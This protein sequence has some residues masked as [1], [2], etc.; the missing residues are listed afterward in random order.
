[1]SRLYWIHSKL[2]T[3]NKEKMKII[4][5]II[6]SFFILCPSL[7]QAQENTNQGEIEG[8]QVVI[9]KNLEITLPEAERNFE[10]VPPP[11][12]QASGEENLNYGF[13]YVD[14]T[15]IP[16][17]N[18][19]LRI[20][21][22]KTERPPLPY[23]NYAK[24]GFGNYLSPYLDVY[25]H[26]TP[27]KNASYGANVFHHSAVNGPVDGKNS[28]NGISQIRLHG[29]YMG[30]AVTTGAN[31]GYTTE[32]YR[33]YGY[34][35]QTEVDRDTIKQVFRTFNAG[36]SLATADP[37]ANLRLKGGLNF[38]HKG[39]NFDISE[40]AVHAFMGGY[41]PI[42][43]GISAG[44]DLD[45]DFRSYKGQGTIS[46]NLIRIFPYFIYQSGQLAVK[47]GFN[48]IS[49]N[50]TLNNVS[51]IG[52]YPSITADYFLSEGITVFGILEGNVDKFNFSN[53]T[54][55]NPY[56]K[57]NVPF[58]NTIKTLEMG[59]GIKG[60]VISNLGYKAS[61]TFAGYKNM[62]FFVND[63]IETNKFNIVYD[64]DM[65]NILRLSAAI[66]YS[67]EQKYGLEL[68][69]N[70]F[71]YSTGDVAEAWHRPKTDFTISGWYNIYDKILISSNLQLLSGIKA[72]DP[73]T[74]E[75]TGLSTALDWNAEINY[76]FSERASGFI[77]LNN[78]LGKNYETLYRYPV[79][80]LQVKLGIG[81]SF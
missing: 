56:I 18:P 44:L 70:Y 81:L 31:L 45:F 36:I 23:E 80:G 75:S 21:K 68:A 16:D 1:M 78:I 27:N 79:R 8:R 67:I 60:A 9:E 41:Y 65:T 62:Y 51:S 38:N 14:N 42:N 4:H 66:N 72:L 49:N 6:A 39:D 10:K 34:D 5:N 52:I 53:I 3:P 28:G 57:S 64:H 77:M 17:L 32:T 37:A 15:G 11:A 7:M 74:L 43:E 33:F 40:N 25:L 24:V 26:S 47:A 50:D 76:R 61:A 55:I 63:A 35:P 48:V 71:G 69:I 46:R 12:D 54:S 58:F 13:T 20:M 30:N 73:V 22:I 59:G 2:S 19:T 29:K